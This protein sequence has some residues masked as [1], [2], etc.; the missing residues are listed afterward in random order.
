MQWGIET[1]RQH[2]L[3]GINMSKEIVK[4]IRITETGAPEVM[5]WVDVELGEPGPGEVLIRHHA[6]G[7]NYLS[8][9]HI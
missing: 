9:I 4:A 5:K 3:L 7:L 1:P 2:T 8:L 6:C